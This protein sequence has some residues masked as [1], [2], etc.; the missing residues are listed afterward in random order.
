MY[1]PKTRKLLVLFLI[2]GW[3]I[4]LLFMAK[5][6]KKLFRDNR[7]LMGTFWEVTSPDKKAGRIVF[8]EVSRIEGLLSK[9]RKDSEVYRLNET[10]KLKVS[11]ET[12]SII[13]KSKE[14]SAKTDGA[15]D[16]TVAPL[17]DLWGFTG[18]NFQVPAKHKIDAAL[19]LVGNDKIILHEK[20]NS[21]E[22]KKPGVKIDLGGIAK[23]FTLD[24]AV[25]KLKEAG[26]KD[27][28]I[29]AGG[30]IYAL[31][32]KFGK[33]W[34]IAVKDPGKNGLAETLVLKNRSASTSADYEQFFVKDNKSY[35]HII[36]PKTGFPVESNIGAFTVISDNATEADAL[37]TAIFVLGEGKETELLSKFPQV[38]IKDY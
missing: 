35:G 7:I 12:F 14:I 9:Y 21:V 24:C 11:P 16:I 32:N 2:I 4:T 28:L 1:S 5:P 3:A 18:Q 19:K 20:D 22:F 25:E 34:K 26:I 17:I 13:K 29:D 36:D 30:Q 31:G 33:P 10:G 37:S 6:Q 38:E 27:C 8:N 15:F 23:G